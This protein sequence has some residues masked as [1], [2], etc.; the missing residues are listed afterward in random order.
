MDIKQILGTDTGKDAF[1]VKTNH[2][3]AEI[4][5]KFEDVDAELL[6][7]SNIGHTHLDKADLINGTVPL[8]QLPPLDYAPA[9][10]DHNDL[11]YDKANIDNKVADINTDISNISQNMEQKADKQ[12]MSVNWKTE[13][14]LPSAYPAYSTTYYAITTGTIAG[15]NPI[16][17]VKTTRENASI[18]KQE[19]F[20]TSGQPLKYRLRKASSDEWDTWKEIATTDKIDISSTLVNG[21]V[22]F[23]T[24]KLMVSKTGNIVT[25]AGAIKDG[26][27]TK[28][29]TLFTIPE[30]YRPVGYP[31]QAIANQYVNPTVG[32]LYRINE[33]GTVLIETDYDWV[34]GVYVFNVS[35]PI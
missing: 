6:E 5:Q 35:Y 17:I 7:K 8:T 24:R 2:N 22:Q 25:L 21:W 26:V 32:R 16:V 15:F 20:R 23:A 3:F 18:C 31:I 30:G 10:H 33:N 29:T 11:Y 19:I 14:D 4:G 34:A 13:A 1:L 28:G 27:V 9:I 12:W